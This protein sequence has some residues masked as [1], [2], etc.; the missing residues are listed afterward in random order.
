VK[1]KKG[2][3]LVELLVVISIIAILLAVLIPSMNRA[4]EAAKRVIC[5]NGKKQI[6]LGIAAYAADY[7]GFMPQCLTNY[8]GVA[9]ILRQKDVERPSKHCFHQLIK[10]LPPNFLWENHEKRCD[11]IS[12]FVPAGAVLG[13]KN[14]LNSPLSKNGKTENTDSELEIFISMCAIV[15]PKRKKDDDLDWMFNELIPSWRATLVDLRQDAAK[16]NIQLSSE[17][18]DIT[19]MVDD[20]A[21]L[22]FEIDI[23]ELV[24]KMVKVDHKI[25]SMFTLLLETR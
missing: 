24:T 21:D 9:Q 7:D 6:A 8:L 11:A 25:V 22:Y 23:G 15:F 17:L 4:K 3:T 5:S 14:V 2:F 20:I 16:N 18:D 19:D 12:T 13:H 1:T 10:H